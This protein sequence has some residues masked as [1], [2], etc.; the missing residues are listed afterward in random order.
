MGSQLTNEKKHKDAPAM[1]K[2]KMFAER[3]D[4]QLD[5]MNNYEFHTKYFLISQTQVAIGKGVISIQESAQQISTLFFLLC[6]SSEFDHL[7]HVS[8]RGNLSER[9]M[10]AVTANLTSSSSNA[11]VTS[12]N[13]LRKGTAHR[14]TNSLRRMPPETVRSVS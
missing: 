7:E 6:I 1:R 5:G 12:L 8:L 13:R 14:G 3:R 10:Q 11:C 9:H 2:M 4:E